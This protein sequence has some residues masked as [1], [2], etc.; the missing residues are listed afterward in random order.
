MGSTTT[1]YAGNYIYQNGNLQFF[2]HPEGYTTPDGSGGYDYVYQYKD[3]LGNVRLSYIDNNGTLEI[4]E[5]NNYYPFGLKHK[6]Y[7]SDI[8][9]LG[10]SVAQRWKYNDV[11][12]EEGLG[13]DLYE[14]PLR[15]YDPAIGRFTGIDPVTH[16]SMSTF[17]AFDNNPVYW[18]DPSGADAELE[19]LV[20]AMLR[21]SGSG[22]TTYTNNGDG[23]FSRTGRNSSPE[24]D[25]SGESQDSQEDDCCPKYAGNGIAG[26]GTVN[27]SNMEGGPT[28]GYKEAAGAVLE[29][30]ATFIPLGQALRILRLGKYTRAAYH[31]ALKLLKSKG[32]ELLASGKS[33]EEVVR[34][35]SPARN[36]V[37]E[38]VRKSDSWIG[39]KI[40][41]LRNLRKYGNK[42]GPNVDDVARKH[43]ENGVTDWKKV[44]DN[45]WKTDKNFD[46]LK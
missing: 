39:R 38:A 13:L 16:Y 23:T 20:G 17:T 10:N 12:F 40:A 25:D 33:Y 32:D 46:K 44:Y 28:E 37:K 1:E 26:I 18:A 11:E 14:M 8:S 2:N 7:N 24:N 21:N 31:K 29:G 45:I 22:S 15:N 43:T 34:L 9:P 4:I 36:A 27:P 35:I 5:E 19:D 41:E 6:G 42:L 3:H 30:V